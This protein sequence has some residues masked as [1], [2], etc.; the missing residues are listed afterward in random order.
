MGT[1]VVD[2]GADWDALPR[3]W[4]ELYVPEGWRAEIVE[5]KITMTPPPGNVHDLIAETVHRRLVVMIPEQ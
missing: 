1:A 5:G 4:R 3:A 2:H